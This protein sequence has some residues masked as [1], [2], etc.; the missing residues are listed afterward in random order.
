M[1]AQKA[2]LKELA[3]CKFRRLLA[4]NKALKCTDVRI[5]DMVLAY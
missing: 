1:T 5:G 3:D 4:Y 2:V